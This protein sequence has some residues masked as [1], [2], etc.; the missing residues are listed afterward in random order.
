MITWCCAEPSHTLCRWS[1][2][3]VRIICTTCANHPLTFCTMGKGEW[4][5]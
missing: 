4:T 5:L 2:Q 1:A 3:N